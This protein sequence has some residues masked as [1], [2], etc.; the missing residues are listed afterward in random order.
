MTETVIIVGASHAGAQA[1]DSLRREGFK[2]RI[3]LV[4]DE[5]YLPYQRPPLSK[6]YLLG[7]LPIERLA[8]RAATFYEQ[9]QVDKRL[10]TRATRIDPAQKLLRL[11][12]GS[13]LSY[14]KLILC[15]GSRVRKLTCPGST[16]KG[17][18]YVRTVDDIK[19]M[20]PEFGP[21]KRMVVIG[22]GYIGLET[23]AAARKLGLEVVVLE[24]ADRCL[25]RVTAP[26]VSD[27]YTRRH[28]QAGVQ[29]LVNTRVEALLG[30]QQ[31]E[32]VQC[33]GGET[34]PADIVVVGVGIV[35]EVELAQAAGIKCDNGI[36]VDQHCCT[37]DPNIYAAGDC[38]N[39]P[40][41]RYGGRV[42]LESVDNAVEQARVAASCIC[43][44]SIEHAHTP[45]FWSD[46]Y[47]VKLQTAGLMQGHDVQVVRGDPQ[48][49]QFSVWYFKEGELLAVDA[50]N[51]PGDFMT[52]KRWI[53]ERKHPD[54]VKVADVAQ[55]LKTL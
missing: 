14:D 48:S 41:I 31:V 42:R 39:H 3:V 46:Q 21:G 26:V 36:V 13:E 28:A 34:I 12:D 45:W 10:N 30:A 7:E 47:E 23:A 15:V 50:I 52:A 35:P 32:A 38:T 25:N 17:V 33:A 4:G 49:G 55:D 5:S 44:K 8:I 29:L 1:I 20:Q 18:H 19:Q 24:M 40:S 27:F 2:G 54:P 9:H 22:A 6:K 43:G 53:G 51:R 16:L 11:G 37:S